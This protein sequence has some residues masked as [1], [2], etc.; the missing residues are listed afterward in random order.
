M[1]TLGEWW[2]RLWYRLNRARLEAALNE[3]LRQHRE[4][5]GDDRRFGSE[6]RIREDVRAVWGWEWLD[7]G[8]TDVAQSLRAL[9]R[10]AVY[11][12]T[13]FASVVIGLGLVA[14]TLGV[15]ES[16]SERALPYRDASRLFHVRYAPPGPWEP[17]NVR[18][19]DWA[20]LRDV[21]P[22]A[23]AVRGARMYPLEPGLVPLRTL[24]V[25]ASFFTGLGVQAV[26]G[27]TL[28]DDDFRAD[29][30][31]VALLSHAIWRSQ[32]GGDSSAIGQLFRT[33]DENGRDQQSFRI[34]GVLPPTFYFGRDSRDQADLVTQRREPAQAYMI[35]L[36][37]GV[38]PATAEQRIGQTLRAISSD[39]PAD[40]PGVQLESVHARYVQ[41]V[42]PV[43]RTVTGAS[44][45][46]LAVVVLNVG[47]LVLLRSLKRQ[48]ESAIR[49]ALG[50][51]RWRLMRQPAVEAALLC[52]T[53]LLGALGIAWLS[54]RMF[55]PSIAAYLGRP[56]PRGAEAI[57]LSAGPMLLTALAALLIMVTMT[58]IPVVLA[59]PGRLVA[60][61][62]SVERAGMVGPFMRRARGLLVVIEIGASVSLLIWCGLM[63]R[64][65]FNLVTA[66]RGFDP[67]GVVRARIEYPA[68]DFPES[69]RRRD[70]LETLRSSAYAATNDS[71]VLANW[72]PYSETPKQSVETPDGRTVDAGVLAVSDG[73][74]SALRVAMASGRDF[75]SSD[76]PGGPPVVVVSRTLAQRFWGDS[77]ALGR[78]VRMLDRS[79]GVAEASP[80]MAVVGVVADV[81]QSFGDDDRADVY[82]NYMQDP[83]NG[84]A[85]VYTRTN[86]SPE[87]WA[88]D[89]GVQ[90]AR[91][92]P[93]A[94]VALASR[95]A[96]Q[97]REGSEAVFLASLLSAFAL[98][99][100][101]LAT[102]GMVGVTAYAVRQ[103]QREMAIRM[104]LGATTS[105]IRAVFLR[106]GLRSVLAGVA[107][108]LVLSVNGARVLSTRVHGVDTADPLTYAGAILLMGGVMVL[109]VWWTAR[110]AAN[111]RH[112]AMLRDVDS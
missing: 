88:A 72:P 104:A 63:L 49:A 87:Q 25:D 59:S 30:E 46:V 64:S 19:L 109:S 33:R 24:Q 85:T 12:L 89:L 86:R 68:T 10:D 6:L 93:R 41:D 51:G 52:A 27:R 47:V 54:A 112:F 14:A 97:D 90:V 43:L 99:T 48:R 17:E 38:T 102:V 55:G 103:R 76:R 57:A 98:F 35:R 1:S 28:G 45:L 22:N 92:S 65:S 91:L 9:R 61:L 66:N 79:R 8:L 75:E 44:L 18:H 13:V 11:A 74:F 94:T 37:S 71:L 62:R 21:V 96:E 15:V 70:F 29:A 95:L 34:V 39:L 23:I 32:W 84:F 83:P 40:W 110:G 56:A 111:E 20:A 108:G 78:S 58:T 60:T 101:V 50:A 5:L 53:G 69:T 2:R 73:Y 16:Y 42:R 100:L 77:S 80:W 67:D 26:L 31:P 82:T 81:R 3:E 105:A 107:A 36:A 7:H 4:A 106:S